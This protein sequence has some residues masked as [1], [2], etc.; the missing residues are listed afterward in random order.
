M[1]PQQK[2]SG[3]PLHLLW[4]NNLISIICSF[5]PLNLSRDETNMYRNNPDA[6]SFGELLFSAT[7]LSKMVRYHAQV[8]TNM[9]II[10]R[11]PC[12]INR[13][14]ITKRSAPTLIGC[15]DRDGLIGMVPATVL[16]VKLV[17]PLEKMVKW[18]VLGLP[19]LML[20]LKNTSRNMSPFSVLYLAIS[21]VGPFLAS[22]LLKAGQMFQKKF[23]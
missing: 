16:G 23:T 4:K 9:K 2:D 14:R 6:I 7:D 8:V 10:Y 3:E 20:Y 15:K 5:N 19:Y 22:P 21:I 17:G 12:S 11:C 1:Y 18:E 13:T